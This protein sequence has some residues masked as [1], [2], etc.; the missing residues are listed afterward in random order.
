MNSKQA[1]RRFMAHIAAA[2]EGARFEVGVMY[3]AGRGWRVYQRIGDVGL[4]MAA[5]DARGLVR[6]F[7]QQAAKP[8]WRAAA[9]DLR[10]LF[11]EMKAC[12]DDVDR[13][14]RAGVKPPD[15]PN[16]VQNGGHA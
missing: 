16:I 1:M 11:A 8:Q 10:G 13:K 5:A 4:S 12:A 14:N 7:E 15:H 3:D 9:E 6:T 2:P